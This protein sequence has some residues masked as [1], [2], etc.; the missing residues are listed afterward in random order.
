MAT[1]L[2]HFCDRC[3][4]GTAT[5]SPPPR[6]DRPP[7]LLELPSVIPPPDCQ[8][9]LS[10][11]TLSLAASCL[12]DTPTELCLIL[13]YAKPPRSTLF[14]SRLETLV[15]TRRFFNPTFLLSEVSSIRRFLNPSLKESK[16]RKRRGNRNTSHV[17]MVQAPPQVTR[18]SNN[19]QIAS[20]IE[21][22]QLGGLERWLRPRGRD[23]DFLCPA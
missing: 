23:S 22:Q 13:R 1:C 21:S 16:G 15:V 2:I 6:L 10:N 14:F 12:P 8:K 7:S 19:N 20:D 18:Y 4:F 5:S 17:Y 11:H 3:R 9:P